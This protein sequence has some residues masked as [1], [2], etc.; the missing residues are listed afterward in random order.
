MDKTMK[1]ISS[2]SARVAVTVILSG[3]LT[4]LGIAQDRPYPVEYY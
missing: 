3:M 4:G 2:M 1:A